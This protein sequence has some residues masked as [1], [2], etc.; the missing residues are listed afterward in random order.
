MAGTGTPD[1]MSGSAPVRAAGC[2][3]RCERGAS[4]SGAIAIE[5]RHARHYTERDSRIIEG[6]GDV[7]A[8]TVDNA[9]SFGRLR[10]LAAEEERSRIARDLHDRLGQWLSYISFELE[11]I[12]TS[13]EESSE[14]LDRLYSDVQ[15][16][17]DE[18]RE[19]LRQLRSGV[20]A[21]RSL[22]VV[23]EELVGRFNQRGET[24]AY[25]QVTAPDQRLPVRVENELLRVLQEGLS[26]VAK[27]A[28]ADTVEVTWDV[29]DGEGTLTIRDDG[30]GFD[31]AKGVRDSAYGLVGMRERADMI[32]ARLS[33]ESNPGLGTTVTVVAGRSGHGPMEARWADGGRLDMTPERGGLDEH[34][35]HEDHD[36]DRRRRHRGRDGSRG[37]ALACEVA[38]RQPERGDG[39]MTY[40][41]LLADDHRILRESVRRSFESA[42]EEIVG[43][44][45]DGEEACELARELQ[46][47]VIVM[48]L[49][50]PVLDG[51][52]ATKRI[53]EEL[54]ATKVVVLTMHD[55]VEAT[56]RALE[57]G[58]VGFLTKG[59]SFAVV[60][61]TVRKAA[62]GE[63][64]LTPEL[65]DSMLQVA[66]PRPGRRATPATSRSCPIGR[67]RSCRRSP[68]A[69]RRSR[70]PASWASRRRPCT[71]TSTPS[72]A[73]STPRASPTRCCPR[74][75]SASSTSTPP[76]LQRADPRGRS[77][78]AAG[79]ARLYAL[80]GIV[81]TDERSHPRDRAGRSCQPLVP[82]KHHPDTGTS[83][84][85][86]ANV[87]CDRAAHLPRR[88]DHL[89]PPHP[90]RARR[91]PSGR[92]RRTGRLGRVAGRRPAAA[93]APTG[94]GAGGGHAPPTASPLTAPQGS[95]R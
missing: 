21:D 3:A 84:R 76:A 42:G 55:D 89:V 59:S 24:V 71:T 73:S 85:S 83:R 34:D 61:D 91:R 82:P 74:C 49:T 39:R 36:E 79:F 86:C 15:T 27:H 51:I 28:R 20:T 47:D 67:W 94:A 41:I 77:R 53:R 33:I 80:T 46:P 62:A 35:D 16:A 8:L 40:R 69:R 9:R 44:A 60:L 63:T 92:R 48:D 19:T 57:A 81:A 17:I 5:H 66:T 23:A 29:G 56:R 45:G 30:R 65:A 11:R 90:P 87:I 12:I 18:L 31:A 93:P 58:A 38:D 22:A 1:R 54:P 6:L 32:G 75:A 14:E 37:A 78:S 4:S 64:G 72:T 13:S 88:S 7:L 95:R 25:L 43:E 26:N 52:G 68:T 10:T 50:M 2:T 70:S